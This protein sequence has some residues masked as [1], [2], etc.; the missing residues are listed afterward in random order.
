M[1]TEKKYTDI[2][3]RVPSRARQL[4][5]S[6]VNPSETYILLLTAAKISRKCAEFVFKSYFWDLKLTSPQ[7][8]D[9]VGH[10]NIVN[11]G[12]TVT[13]VLMLHS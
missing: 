7:K 8:N 6:L 9:F 2:P 5:R 11:G 13:A 1:K 4:E 10:L 3:V 12:N